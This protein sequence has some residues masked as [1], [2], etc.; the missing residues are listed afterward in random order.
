MALVLFPAIGH[1]FHL[2]AEQFGTWCAIAIHDTSSVVGAATNYKDSLG[3]DALPIATTIKLERALW[4]IPISLATAYF[5]KS[6]GKIKIPYFI[7]YFVLAIIVSS[8]FPIDYKI[9]GKVPYD[10]IF[11]FGRKGL[12]VT[13]FLIGSG[14]SVNAI[15]Q[16]GFK[17]ILQG[18]LLWLLIGGL[19]LMVIRSIIA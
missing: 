9:V 14:L 18:V 6:Q 11:L 4:I 19:S 17:P 10:Y 16:V 2:S 8:Y 12:I 1:Y 13:L 7:L 15:K 3:H 5:Q